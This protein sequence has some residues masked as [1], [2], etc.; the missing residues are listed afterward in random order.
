MGLILQVLR[1]YRPGEPIMNGR[2][3]SAELKH[4]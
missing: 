4:S 3:H 2:K 1:A